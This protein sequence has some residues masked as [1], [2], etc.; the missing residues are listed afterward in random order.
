MVDRSVAYM[1]DRTACHHA[2]SGCRP[3]IA[4]EMEEGQRLIGYI[5]EYIKLIYTYYK[6][7]V[8]RV[9]MHGVSQTCCKRERTRIVIR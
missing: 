9:D 8:G 2:F 4:G 5:N 7:V 1:T 3:Y 6:Y